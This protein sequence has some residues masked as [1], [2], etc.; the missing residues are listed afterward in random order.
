[1][2]VILVGTVAATSV[3]TAHRS[4]ATAAATV[5][6]LLGLPAISTA[7]SYNLSPASRTLHP[8]ATTESTGLLADYVSAASST[9][10]LSAHALQTIGA[11]S[12]VIT[13]DGAPVRR[14][15]TDPD[16]SFSYLLH[17]S[18]KGTQTVR[19][20]E[21]GSASSSYDVLVGN[22]VVH[23][24]R[25]TSADYAFGG[26]A[27]GLEHYSFTV[28]AK[29]IAAD[30]TYRLTFR[31]TAAPGDGAQIA[32]VWDSATAGAAQ[33]PFGGSVTNPKGA[34]TT[35]STVLKSDIFGKPYVIYDFGKDVAGTISFNADSR[36]GSPKVGVA[37]SESTQ[38]LTTQSDFSQ[39]PSGVAT[40]THFFQPAPGRSA[41]NDSVI[42]GGFRY[43]MVFLDTPGELAVSNLTLHFTADP[44]NP[45]LRNYQGAFL[46]SD[47]TL[48][49]LWYSGAYTTQL[50]TI[51]SNTGRPY[52]AQPGPV[53]NNVTVAKGTS[54]LSDGAK[55]DRLD[56]GGDNV[57]SGPVSLLTTGRGQAV[58]NSIEWFG[59]HP[60]P[61]G[62][63]PGVYLPAP[64]GFQSAWGE[65]A[66]WWVHNYWNYYLYTGDR[67]FLDSYY[68]AMKGNLAWF[69]TQ[70]GS[71]HLWNVSGSTNGHWGYGESGQETYDN[72]VYALALQDAAAAAAVEEDSSAATSY[73]TRASQTA[74]AVN[75]TLWDDTAGAY[76]V[77]PNSAA[78]PLD[79]NAM[80][81]VAGIATGDRAT[82]AL[83][84]VH[85]TLG[86]P[87]GE[88]AVDSAD[89]NSVSN[90][91]SPFVS[92]QELLADS[93]LGTS[94]G[95]T[96]AISDLRRTWAHMLTGDTAG[97]LWETVSPTGGL[98]LGSYTSMAHGWGT[99][100][101]AYLTNQL[102]G[103]TPTSG[104]FATFQIAPRPAGGVTWAEGT[105]PTPQGAIQAAWRQTGQ[106][107]QIAVTA[108]TGSTYRIVLPAGTGT[109]VVGGNTVYRAGHAV[110]GAA[111]GTVSRSGTDLVLTGLHGTS[112]IT[113]S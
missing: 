13:V 32:G 86:T 40:E 85:K 68:S 3:T 41:V 72:A 82:R 76:R 16:A 60:F 83:A 19:V 58:Q 54:F 25:P 80:A 4:P 75:A 96:Q 48:N 27:I 53:A 7:Q 102:L 109:V 11:G 5:G 10:E 20:E 47:T 71:D 55:R 110:A 73:T 62:E 99:G 111:T 21:A 2:A 6:G 24:R 38:F 105:V 93:A 104:G 17:G 106:S 31:N 87:N 65:Y 43:L 103:V 95:D 33:A 46:S 9:S 64:A 12:S 89:N 81:V 35:G 34:L 42:R 45:D 74:A 22:T 66:A 101:T 69:A 36:S 29:Y 94:A 56:W 59:D 37:F 8:T 44:D 108:P 23:T 26:R 112:V 88:L 15:G 51:A 67:S 70:V 84:F 100:P 39:D 1:M 18:G 30:G 78:H 113:T 79:G 52:P 97:T 107:F 91:I 98:G 14:S 63:I 49:K 28:P 92:Y 77:L 50:A 90:V 61:N 57:V